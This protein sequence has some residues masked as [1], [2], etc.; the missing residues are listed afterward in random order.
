MLLVGNRLINLEDWIPTILITSQTEYGIELPAENFQ[1]K[2]SERRIN[3]K[4]VR[5]G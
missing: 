4:N 1:N 3:H 2:P 5:L